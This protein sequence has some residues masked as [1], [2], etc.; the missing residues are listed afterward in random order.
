MPVLSIVIPVYN[1]ERYLPRCLDS[2]LGQ[3]FSDFEVIAVN[4]GSTDRSLSI[5]KEYEARNEGRLT[6]LTKENGGLSDARNFGLARAKGKYVAFVD[7]DDFILPSF[8]R[9]SVEKM[10]KEE[11]DLLLLD[12]FYAYEDGETG[13]GN[14]IKLRAGERKK[15]MLL[16]PPMACLRVYRRDLL[17]EAP[18]RKGIYYEDLEMTPRMLLKA[19]RVSFLPEALYGYVQRAGSIMNENRF[20]PRWLDIFEVLASLREAFSQDEKG[21]ELETE[22]E[23]LHIEHLLRTAALRLCDTLE[24]KAH[25]YALGREVKKH[26]PHWRKNPYL[27][28]A[29]FPFRLT[30]WLCAAG[31]RRAL[32]CL[33]KWKG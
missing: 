32:A 5:L 23:F 7:S 28:Q 31:M 1:V 17:G 18:F 11:A 8:A 14:V 25:F 19:K 21:K 26:Y 29:S 15:E 4:D 13:A 10:E 27:K 6:V 20:S 16:A 24:G 3:N 12:F 2:V 9:A 22:L 33:K 30:V